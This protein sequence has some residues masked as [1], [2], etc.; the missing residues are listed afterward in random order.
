[1]RPEY[2]ERQPWGECNICRAVLEIEM[3]MIEQERQAL[4]HDAAD[5][6]KEEERAEE[7]LSPEDQALLALPQH[8]TKSTFKKVG[9]VS[10]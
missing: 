6:A 3:D 5:A 1:M 9:I 10:L 4:E 8:L 7:F 2:I